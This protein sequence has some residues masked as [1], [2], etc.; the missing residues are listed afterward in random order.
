MNSH[1]VNINRVVFKEIVID[2][3]MRTKRWL[4]GCQRCSYRASAESSGSVNAAMAEHETWHRL[5]SDV[6][7]DG[8]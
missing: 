5:K 3:A 8:R 4:A 7:E 6:P 1:W 2:A